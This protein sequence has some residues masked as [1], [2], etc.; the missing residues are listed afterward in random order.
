M[1][2]ITLKYKIDEKE[3]F[4]FSK[5]IRMKRL[6]SKR[7]L[8]FFIGYIV[9]M[10]VVLF[11]S[12]NYITIS[13]L[14]IYIVYFAIICAALFVVDLIIIRIKAKKELESH[15]FLSKNIERVI[16]RE[17]VT[18]FINDAELSVKWEDFVD[19]K[20]TKKL[21]VIKN[22]DGVYTLIPKSAF[23]SDEEIAFFKECIRGIKKQSPR[24]TRRTVKILKENIE[25]FLGFLLLALY[26][27]VH[28]LVLSFVFELHGFDGAEDFLF[29]YSDGTVPL[30]IKC[31][32][33]LLSGFV[34]LPAALQNIYEAVNGEKSGGWFM[35]GVRK[36]WW[37][38]GII[39]L[40]AFAIGMAV[41]FA[42]GTDDFNSVFTMHN[43]IGFAVFV[44]ITS[45]MLAAVVIE[46]NLLR[47]IKGSFTIGKKY[48]WKMFTSLLLVLI[49][50]AILLVI[51]TFVWLNALGI[52]IAVSVVINAIL[53]GY[54][55]ARSIVHYMDAKKYDNT[56]ETL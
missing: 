8:I 22:K 2:S 51:R 48:F 29:I 15:V 5:Y 19:V 47:G 52:W 1:D 12:Q 23:K 44:V 54:L 45:F 16:T 49:V 24:T 3:Y 40:I 28:H 6:F 39:S 4:S 31:I 37:K 43:N 32:I 9:L 25:S 46:G 36:H 38:T 21:Y 53:L 50:D 30:I 20:E 33:I 35:R 14:L 13:E 56:E 11:F 18:R 34:L 26:T 42:I 17:D 55:Y 27:S 10:A 7:T 41:E